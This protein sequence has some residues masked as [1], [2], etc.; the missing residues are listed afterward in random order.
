MCVF[1]LRCVYTIFIWGSST[2]NKY[3]LYFRNF[4]HAEYRDLAR[5]PLPTRADQQK[6]V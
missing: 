5:R 2:N 1:I 4:L 3:T 6:L